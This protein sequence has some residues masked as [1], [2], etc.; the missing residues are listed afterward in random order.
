[1]ND[2]LEL[3]QLEEADR[4]KGPK[5]LFDGIKAPPCVKVRAT[6]QIVAPLL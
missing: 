4:N 1:M 3:D 2:E 5:G 6:R